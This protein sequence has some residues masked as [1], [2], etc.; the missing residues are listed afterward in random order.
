MGDVELI[1]GNTAAA[2]IEFKKGLDWQKNS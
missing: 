2:E 1:L